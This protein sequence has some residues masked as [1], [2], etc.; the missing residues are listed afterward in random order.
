MAEELAQPS[1]SAGL[2]DWDDL[3]TA[4]PETVPGAWL[5]PEGYCADAHHYLSINAT[6]DIGLHINVMSVAALVS[7]L[8]LNMPGC[9][10]RTRVTRVVNERTLEVARVPIDSPIDSPEKFW[11]QGY[12]LAVD[13]QQQLFWKVVRSHG[14]NEAAAVLAASLAQ[15][16]R[17]GATLVH[18][19]ERVSNV[20]ILAAEDLDVKDLVPGDIELV[21]PILGN[22]I[23]VLST[24]ALLQRLQ[25]IDPVVADRLGVSPA[26]FNVDS[27]KLSRIRASGRE[28]H[29]VVPHWW[30]AVEL[31]S[32][33]CKD[34]KLVHLDVC[35]P[36]YNIF[37]Y[38]DVL[39]E[40]D[41]APLYVFES[42]AKLLEP[43]ANPRL[44]H[45]FSV[46]VPSRPEA[47]SIRHLRA[48]VWAQPVD[49]FL[50]RRQQQQ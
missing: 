15:L 9:Q 21:D 37:E 17:M 49:Q 23:K 31:E 40:R 50:E 41:Q 45:L 20:L 10:Q 33:E 13:R 19:G 7:R 44:S 27:E 1:G 18:Q 11:P 4:E 36:A 3:D 46:Q 42:W 8:L 14:C 32:F 2:F 5:T 47:C 34:H 24:Y 29:E 25:G 12:K 22:R 16:R 26:D 43:R 30:V 38:H 28:L 6:G 39:G 48:C 35:G